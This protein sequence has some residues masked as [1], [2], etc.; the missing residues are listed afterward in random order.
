MTEEVGRICLIE[1]SHNQSHGLLLSTTRSMQ[2]RIP[3]RLSLEF[4][5]MSMARL[6]I[7]LA[8]DVT[9]PPKERIKVHDQVLS[10]V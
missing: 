8:V 9:A 1:Q 4:L 3:T 5:G 7:P 10:R 6:K 2:P